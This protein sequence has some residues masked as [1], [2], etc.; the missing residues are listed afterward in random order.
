[1]SF[2]HWQHAPADLM[3]LTPIV[4]VMVIDDL[5]DALPMATALLNAGISLF[6]V[7]LRTDV[8]L[9]AIRLL[10]KEIPAATVGVGTVTNP[11]ELAAAAAAGA[12]FAI[13]PGITDELLVA[14]KAG[15]MP[16]IPGI[17]TISELMQAKALG[18]THFKFFPA[19]ASGG[20]AMLKS[21]AGPF[22]NVRFCPTG[23]IHQGNYR[24]YLA[25]NNVLCV[26]G[27][28]ILPADAIQAKDWAAIE[29][30]SKDAVQQV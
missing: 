1:M 28:W 9:E 30:L 10:R 22:P 14:A 26:G 19:E 15:D 5:D 24:D 8:A 11:E 18:Y 23:G 20:V 12:Q 4:P 17:A 27:S 21:I 13:S 29:K 25:L 16:L 2:S 3:Q 6:E 7:T